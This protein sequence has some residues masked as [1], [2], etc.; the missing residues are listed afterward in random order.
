MAARTFPRSYLLVPMLALLAAGLVACGGDDEATTGPD[1]VVQGF[2]TGLATGDGAAACSSF[3][4]SSIA[5]LEETEGTSCEDAVI[6][7]TGDV[8]EEDQQ[9]VA[10]STFEITEETDTTASVTATKP[11]GQSQSFELTLE[12]GEWKLSDAG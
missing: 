8:S 7:T 2:V 5:D 6:A 1:E 4:E 12:D 10:D 9:A 3:S 11:D